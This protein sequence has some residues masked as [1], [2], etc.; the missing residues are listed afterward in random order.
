MLLAAITLNMKVMEIDTDK[1][2]SIKYYLDEIRQYLNNLI[3]SHRTQGVWKVQLI[4]SVNPFSSKD[5][6]EICTKYNPIDNIEISIANE[7]IEQ[8]F[9]SFFT[10]M[11]KKCRTINERK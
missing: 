4:M 10:K 2:L 7:I 9:D 3:V 6:E 8:L 1:A 11:P 5:S